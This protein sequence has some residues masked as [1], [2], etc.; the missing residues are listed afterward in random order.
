MYTAR[1]VQRIRVALLTSAV[2]AS[3]LRVRCACRNRLLHFRCV[4]ASVMCIKTVSCINVNIIVCQGGRAVPG[5]HGSTQNYQ[6]SVI[7]QYL[8]LI[9]LQYFMYGTF[10]TLGAFMIRRHAHTTRPS[11]CKQQVIVA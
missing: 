1:D 2:P 7:Q 3:A 10:R 11:V 9:R 4:L 6:V 5:W 8:L